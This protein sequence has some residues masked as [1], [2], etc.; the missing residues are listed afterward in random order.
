[1]W[2][3]AG[4]LTMVFL[5]PA[6]NNLPIGTAYFLF[7]STM[8]ITGILLGNLW[9]KEKLTKVKLIAFGLSFLGLLTI[10]R[11]DINIQDFFFVFT[12]LVGG[13]LIGLW[14]TSSKKISSNY[15]LLQIIIFGAIFVIVIGSLGIIFTREALPSFNDTGSWFWIFVFAIVELLATA[16]VVSGFKF[17]EAQK[18]SLLM[19]LEAVFGAL[20]G[21]LLFS[22]QISM[23]L[24]TGGSLIFIAAMV[25]NLNQK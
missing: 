4:S 10:Y 19:P 5:Y 13:A 9:F 12:A 23:G 14:N 8:I 2:G 11:I 7:Y 18:A 3:I 6:F 25:S 1:M 17:L 24:F 22:E 21:Y 16:F 15:D 20:F